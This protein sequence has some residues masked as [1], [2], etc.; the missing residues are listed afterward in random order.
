MFPFTQDLISFLYV[1]R[2]FIWIIV[3]INHD[4]KLAKTLDLWFCESTRYKSLSA[5]QV[6]F[7]MDVRMKLLFLFLAF[8]CLIDGLKV[9]P[10]SNT[11][12]QFC[13]NRSG[14]TIWL[15]GYFLWYSS[16]QIFVETLLY[17]RHVARHSKRYNHGV[18][19]ITKH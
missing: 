13:P 7:W 6:V 1:I 4:G 10:G 3:I 5:L 8:C 2:I 12:D 19:Y 11:G 16:P 17:A 15:T 18:R 9:I 14:D